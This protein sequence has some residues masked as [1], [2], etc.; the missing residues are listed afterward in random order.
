MLVVVIGIPV[1][2]K[3]GA[4]K[5][6]L[7]MIDILDLPYKTLFLNGMHLSAGGWIGWLSIGTIVNVVCHAIQL[8][9]G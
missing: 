5:V 9:R 6:P 8:L 1:M 3:S 7:E 2:F 4:L